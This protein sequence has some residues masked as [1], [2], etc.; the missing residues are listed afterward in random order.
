MS[1][2]LKPCPFCGSKAFEY[3]PDDM[4]TTRVDCP[5]CVTHYGLTI[6]EWNR[7]ASPWRSCDDLLPPTNVQVL[8]FD[9]SEHISIAYFRDSFGRWAN[10]CGDTVPQPICWMHLP[11]GPRDE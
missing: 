10:D 11:K 9:K 6:D 3:I 1:D 8:I 2:Q 7:R 5:E 4:F